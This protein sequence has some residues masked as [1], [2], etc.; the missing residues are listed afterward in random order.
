MPIGAVIAGIGAVTSIVGGIS[1]A[2]QASKNNS[3]AK[4]N[5]KAQQKA[6]EKQAKATNEYNAKVDFAKEFNYK[7]Q[8]NFAYNNAIKNWQKTNEIQDYKYLQSLKLY[9]KSESIKNQ[10]KNL[11]SLAAS[12]AI[13]SEMTAIDDM[14]LTQQFQN[15]TAINTLKNVYQEAALST[16]EQGLKSLQISASKDS[17]FASLQNTM[18]QARDETAMEKESALIKGLIAQGKASLGQ[19]GVSSAKR[20]QSTS[21]ELQRGLMSLE[22]QMTG[23][24]KQAQ[25]KMLEI[26]A[27]ASLQQ[28]GVGLNLQKIANTITDAEEE[29]DFNKKV[30]EANMESFLTQS[31][32]N[33]E[34]INLQ[35]KFADLNVDASAMLFPEPLS[36]NPMPEMPPTPMFVK[37]M[38]AT[39]AFVPSPAQQS[40]MAPLLQGIGGAATSLAGVDFSNLGGGGGGGS[41]T[42]NKIGNFGGGSMPGA[43]S[44]GGTLG[45]FGSY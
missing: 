9:E 36:Y 34:Q 6:A 1:G 35:K 22:R 19:A 12:Q 30:S 41:I 39:A 13:E 15:E 29:A 26:N 16:Q 40:T 23:E 2:N 28:L 3:T 44:P 20:Q 27:D 24:I 11:N 31:T 25:I 4:K 17:G 5:A 18:Q 33:I 21:A 14:F 37:S 45:T 43:F 10:N 42:G 38:K 32:K 7:Q 8:T